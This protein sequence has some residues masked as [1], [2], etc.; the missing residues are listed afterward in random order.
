MRVK[1]IQKTTKKNLLETIFIMDSGLVCHFF[2]LFLACFSSNSCPFSILCG[3]ALHNLQ[4]WRHLFQQFTSQWHDFQHTNA[5]AHTFCRAAATNIDLRASLPNVIY[6]LG[7][8][9]E[10]SWFFFPPSLSSHHSQFIAGVKGSITA[11]ILPDYLFFSS[12]QCVCECIR[13][14]DVLSNKPTVRQHAH[15]LNWVPLQPA[16]VCMCVCVCIL[17]NSLLTETHRWCYLILSTPNTHAD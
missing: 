14:W 4:L 12:C 8:K 11:E 7:S 5:H 1:M 2:R 10:R 9:I 17:G 3:S 15:G 16:C 6:L 13:E